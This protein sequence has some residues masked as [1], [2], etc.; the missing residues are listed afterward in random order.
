[1]PYKTK[2]ANDNV[3]DKI[4]NFFPGSAQSS[5][6]VRILSSFARKYKHT[7]IPNRNI[8]INKLYFEISNSRKKRCLT[9]NTSD[10]NDL[11]Q[12]HK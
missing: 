3:G 5:S 7:Y 1:M 6:I 10:V 9:I 12:L 11:V 4:F 8:W 2:L